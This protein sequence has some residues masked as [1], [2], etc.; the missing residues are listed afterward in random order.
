MRKATEAGIDLS[1]NVLGGLAP[2][3]YRV[4]LLRELAA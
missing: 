4:K 2:L 3:E 1:E